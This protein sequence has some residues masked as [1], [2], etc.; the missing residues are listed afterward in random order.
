MDRQ[1]QLQEILNS[2]IKEL[3]YRLSNNITSYQ[4]TIILKLQ[5]AW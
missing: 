4:I 3:H 1:M 5:M 2:L